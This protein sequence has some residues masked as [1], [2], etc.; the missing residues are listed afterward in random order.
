MDKK[1]P[2]EALKPQKV[3]KHG[4]IKLNDTLLRILLRIQWMHSFYVLMDILTCEDFLED[5]IIK[6]EKQN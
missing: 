6:N 4:Q 2:P 1:S 3:K 5:D